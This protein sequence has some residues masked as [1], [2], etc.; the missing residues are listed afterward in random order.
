MFLLDTDICIYV[1]NQKPGYESILK[2]LDGREQGEVILSAIT[3]AELRFG[4]A[5]SRQQ[6]FKV[7]SSCFLPHSKSRHLMSARPPP[8]G[9]CVPTFKRRVLLSVRLTR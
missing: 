8:M 2:N 4:I 5:A 9:H 1:L 6:N 3:L 7:D